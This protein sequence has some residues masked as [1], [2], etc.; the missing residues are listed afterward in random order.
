[1]MDICQ[2]I[3]IENQMELEKNTSVISQQSPGE[4]YTNCDFCNTH[5]DE[6][7]IEETTAVQKTESNSNVS[8]D[9]GKS[10][11]IGNS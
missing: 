3:L 1:M 8:A 2:D 10:V 4:E 9:S 6:S 5:E 7:F 11:H